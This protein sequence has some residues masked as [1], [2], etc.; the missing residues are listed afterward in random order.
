MIG[1]RNDRRTLQR[2]D[3]TSGSPRPGSAWR[4][5]VHGGRWTRTELRQGR[6]AAFRRTV[7]IVATL[8]LLT[9]CAI[10]PT[11]VEVE[12]VPPGLPA[13]PSPPPVI[14]RFGDWGGHGGVPRLWPH[15]GVDIRAKVGTPVL[16]AADGTVIRVGEQPLAGKFV[17]VQHATDLT[18][19]SYHLSAIAVAVGRAVQRG[20][21]LGRSGMTGNATAP[22]LH[23]GVCRREDGQ[24]GE[25]IKSGWDDPERYWI[26]DN[27]CFVAGHAYPA[28]PVRLTFPLPCLG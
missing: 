5:R 21:A 16:A 20:E 18:T 14:S 26:A 27:P 13:T 6:Q 28:E 17:L 19:A 7:R 25:S 12:R 3:V 15:S 1:A 2:V 9:G 22:H 11:R 10:E 8:L 4:R 24:C 23:F